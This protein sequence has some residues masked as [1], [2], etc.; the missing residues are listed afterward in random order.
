MARPPVK[1]RLESH[2]PMFYMNSMAQQ[3]THSNTKAVAQL[4]GVA[5]TTVYSLCHGIRGW[6]K[7]E[8]LPHSRKGTRGRLRFDLSAVR[9]WQRRTRFEVQ[10]REGPR[11]AAIE[12]DRDRLDRIGVDLGKGGRSD[13]TEWLCRFSLPAAADFRPRN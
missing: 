7:I 10:P 6:R 4:L 1:I 8:P 12:R 9:A 2:F 11:L 3:I 5:I 13:R